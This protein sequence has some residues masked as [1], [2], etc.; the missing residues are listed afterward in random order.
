MSAEGD[1][2][3]MTAQ[4]PVPYGQQQGPQPGPGGMGGPG[5][6][7]PDNMEMLQKVGTHFVQHNSEELALICLL[8]CSK[9][10]YVFLIQYEL[11]L[12]E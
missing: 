3:L 8:L 4:A 7:G 5:G 11:W 1:S 2:S 10:L 12:Y 6:Q 9:I